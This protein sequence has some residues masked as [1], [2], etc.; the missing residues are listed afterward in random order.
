MDQ[1]LKF[2]YLH[3]AQADA[4]KQGVY[5]RLAF[6]AIVLASGAT[7]AVG[8]TV[9][10]SVRFT[11][12]SFGTDLKVYFTDYSFDADE[13]W[14]LG[15]CTDQLSRADKLIKAVD[16]TFDANLKVYLENLAMSADKVVC[17]KGPLP[18]AMLE[19]L[20]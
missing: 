13:R 7:S 4:S 11:D 3:T 14:Y 17:V 2:A 10:M 6:L 5:L 20:P 19:K 15:S 1:G 16:Y 9:D 12:Y 8:Q 18:D